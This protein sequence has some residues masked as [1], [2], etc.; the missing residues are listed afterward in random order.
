LLVIVYSRDPVH[1]L[2]FSDR[3][4]W[5]LGASI[6]RVPRLQLLTQ[7]HRRRG[8]CYDPGHS[9]RQWPGT[10]QRV[11]WLHC[12]S[13]PPAAATAAAPGNSPAGAGSKQLRPARYSI[14]H[15]KHRH[16]T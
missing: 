8:S 12:S 11:L 6:R 14:S 16:A 3:F 13:P 4:L 5:L 2:F 9:D 7:P 1:I 10:C 15:S